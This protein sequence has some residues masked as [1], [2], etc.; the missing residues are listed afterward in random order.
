M[1]KLTPDQF[2]LLDRLSR[3]SDSSRRTDRLAVC[4]ANAPRESGGKWDNSH[5]P[6]IGL[7]LRDLGY[8][9][10]YKDA[11]QYARWDITPTGR[12]NLAEY[13][14][15]RLRTAT[16]K[17]APVTV[18][19]PPPSLPRGYIV[20]SADGAAGEIS[21]THINKPDADK[22]AEKWAKEEPGSTYLVCAVL[23]KVKASIVVSK[24]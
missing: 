17:E 9:T 19:A 13:V 3:Y 14:N 2:Q 16:P 24:E 11:N 23:E 4:M 22:L 7:Q 21:V 18:G 1:S 10:T 5:V 15:I 20:V 6:F 12:A 8:V